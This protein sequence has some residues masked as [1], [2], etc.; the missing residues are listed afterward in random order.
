M[1]PRPGPSESLQRRCAGAIC[2]NTSGNFSG[3]CLP[4]SLT[5]LLVPQRIFHWASG[6]RS[7]LG[8]N[9]TRTDLFCCI[10]QRK[11]KQTPTHKKKDSTIT[12][13]RYHGIS[14]LNS[15]QSLFDGRVHH[16]HLRHVI[17][18]QVVDAP[19]HFVK[20]FGV[21]CDV[22]CLWGVRRGPVDLLELDLSVGF[23][24]TKNY[25]QKMLFDIG[26]EAMVS[27]V[28]WTERVVSPVGRRHDEQPPL[29]QW[30]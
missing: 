4:K 17:V 24:L 8:N 13:A 6:D 23:A 5:R 25:F 28:V 15:G 30:K 1:P 19:N 20:E 3:S 27:R 12:S 21:L 18:E 10:S 2:R 11:N 7:A 22:L 9:G 29:Q 26:R 14:P 16:N